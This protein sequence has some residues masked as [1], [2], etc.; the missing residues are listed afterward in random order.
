MSKIITITLNTAIDNITEIDKFKIG[1]VV[2]ATALRVQSGK[3]INVSRA[4]ASLN[5]STIALGF[6]GTKEL[7]FFN[8]LNSKKFKVRLLPVEDT[9][10]MNVSIIDS[11]YNLII[12]TRALGYKLKEI[13]IEQ[14]IKKMATIL[15]KDDIVVISGSIPNK[16]VS[17]AYYKIIHYCKTKEVKI[18][19]DSSG[20]AL[21]I[22]I[23]A[24]PDIIKP[25]LE[26]LQELAKQKISSESQIVSAAKKLNAGGIKLVIVSN[27]AK[28]IIATQKDETGYWKAFLKHKPS[29]FK[30]LEIGCGDSLIAGISIGLLKS[31][32]IE[33]LLKLAIG[34]AT[35]NLFTKTPGLI[36]ESLVKRFANTAIIKHL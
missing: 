29:K 25:N 3:G 30:G 14:L 16:E 13:D 7:N 21:K 17:N 22:G 12:H 15:K 19:L 11:K 33:S 5:N 32:N 26:E 8:E 28:G 27:G 10:R 31:E 9:T 1:S 6:V 4:I 35:A 36:K 24:I 18:I 23:K 2:K 20:T 34:C